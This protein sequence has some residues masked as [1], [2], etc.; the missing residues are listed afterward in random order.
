MDSIK[1]YLI[2]ICSLPTP[3]TTKSAIKQRNLASGLCHFILQ[4]TILISSFGFL[5]KNVSIDLENSLYALV[6]L[7]ATGSTTYMFIFGFVRREK[8]RKLFVEFQKI[9]NECE[10]RI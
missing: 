6:Q 2:L 8:M 3:E 5:I 7:A 9:Q 1:N 4:L 10:M